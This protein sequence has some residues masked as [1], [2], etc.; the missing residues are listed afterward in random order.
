V[1]LPLPMK[2]AKK[3]QMP[4]EAFEEITAAGQIIHRQGPRFGCPPVEADL[5]P[6]FLIGRLQKGC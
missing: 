1:G 3:L 2:T 4:Q 5:D 6:V